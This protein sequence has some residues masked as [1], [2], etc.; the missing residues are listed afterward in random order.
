MTCPHCNAAPG[1]KC[2]KK[3]VHRKGWKAPC[4]IE[5][6]KA[7]DAIMEAGF[8]ALMREDMRR[9]DAM[10]AVERAR[11]ASRPRRREWP[12]YASLAFIA[13][14]AA[15]G[16]ALCVRNGWLPAGF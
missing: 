9:D 6:D 11:V 16:L 5:R 4:V 14:S 2:A 1:E 12:E 10:R 15:A 7:L 8:A 13:I 3:R